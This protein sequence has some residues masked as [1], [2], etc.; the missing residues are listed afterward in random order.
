MGQAQ[1][2]SQ[3]HSEQVTCILWTHRAALESKLTPQAVFHPRYAQALQGRRLLS[4]SLY[5][6]RHT[7]NSKIPSDQLQK[8]P[9]G[10][11]LSGTIYLTFFKRGQESKRKSRFLLAQHSVWQTPQGQALNP[12]QSLFLLQEPESHKLRGC[13]ES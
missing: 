8:W 5:K 3:Q 1:V 2:P 7:T 10:P 9:W 12:E 13:R 6:C 11:A 4:S